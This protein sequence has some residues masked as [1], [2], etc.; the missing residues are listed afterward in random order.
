MMETMAPAPVDVRFEWNREEFL[1]SFHATTR[2]ARR[3]LPRWV[4]W[5]FLA[6]VWANLIRSQIERS[7]HPVRV[8]AIA[9]AL[10]FVCWLIPNLAGKQF[11]RLRER[12]LGA[13]GRSIVTTFGD[14]GVRRSNGKAESVFP[15]ASL[16]RAVETKE[17]LLIYHRRGNA[18]YLPRRAISPESLGEV[19]ALV[20]RHLGGKAKLR[21]D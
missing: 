2:H 10:L 20:R 6:L 19:R 4:G 21:D 17:F 9:A 18:F 15:W 5:A 7:G 12:E 11:A 14:E 8:I 3:I 16:Q 13:D 1:R